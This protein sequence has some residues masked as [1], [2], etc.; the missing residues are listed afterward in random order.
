MDENIKLVSRIMVSH[1]LYDVS[2]N[3]EDQAKFIMELQNRLNLDV[4]SEAVPGRAGKILVARNQR[5]TF[6]E[7]LK[8]TGIEYN[9]EVENIKEK[10]DLEDAL[11][12]GTST[13]SN[14]SADGSLSFDTIHTYEVLASKYPETVTIVNAGKSFEGRDIKYLKISTTGFQNNNNKPVV[15]LESLL[16]AREWVTLPATLYAIKKLVVDVTEQDLLQNIDWIILPVANPDGYY[17]SRIELFL[18]IHSF[19]SLILYGYGTGQLPANALGLQVLGVNMAQAI[20]RVKWPTNA[21]YVVGNTFLTLYAA[22]GSSNDYGM[23]VGTPFSYCFELPAYMNSASLNG[24][25]VDPDFIE[26]AGFETWEGIKVG[27]SHALY[28][29]SVNFEDQARFIM[30]LQ[31]RL[32]LDV[33]SEAVP[34]RAGKILVAKH[35]R[36]IFQDA[37]KA[38]DIEYNV[39]V[40]NIK[41]KL[42]LED[43][44]LKGASARSNRSADG[45]LSFDTIHTYEVVDAYLEEL[46][47]KYPETVTL[48]NAGKSF[49]GRDIKYL[50]ISSTGF[51]DNRK[52]VVFMQSLLHCREWVTLPATLY[53]IKKL[54]V[55]VTEQDLLQNVDWIILPA[56]F[57]R[58]NRATGYMIGDFCMG[59]DLNRNFD[60]FWSQASSNS[61][62][63][64]T[65]HGRGP[66][67]EPE[68]AIIRD[69]FAEYGSRIE[70]FLDIHSFGSMILYGYGTGQLP[71]NALGVHVLGVNMAQTIDSV[72]WPTNA[73]YIVGNI[74][75]VLYAATGGASDYAMATGTPFSYTFELPAY[76]N[77]ATMNGFLV[78]PDFI[79]QAGYETWEGIKVG[80]RF[81][82]E[83][84]SRKN[85][86]GN[87]Y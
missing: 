31:N 37:L 65:F 9:V 32:N 12:K 61:V 30:E 58:K 78:D 7:A 85:N 16:H 64:D 67:S 22:T 63:M 87:H 79:E 86:L 40:E 1:A 49:E 52:P 26:Q 25:L 45:S 62:C 69:I 13:R 39:E 24:F 41:E 59:V 57:W 42:D 80:A 14:R 68:T 38:A 83:H 4:W 3:F 2:V 77:S 19:G 5:D 23:S 27:A 51:Q 66:F 53:A 73:N 54:V 15:F 20:D 29:V 72:K 35:Q 6:Q 28:D 33:W 75:L 50:K 44:L 46:A 55:D 8:V 71:G 74:F 21:N 48:V 76:R 70:L 18:D 60:A 43:A 10:L 34:G 81:V 84:L 36:D 82:V 56:R 47:S 17:G 11:L